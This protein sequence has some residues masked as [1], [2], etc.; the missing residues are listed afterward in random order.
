MLAVKVVLQAEQT[1]HRFAGI[2][3]NFSISPP[4][5]RDMIAFLQNKLLKL[6]S[7][8]VS[9]A[10]ILNTVYFIAIF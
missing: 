7:K 1:V 6:N 5:Y 2:Q 9:E 3:R 4:F 8:Y 10:S